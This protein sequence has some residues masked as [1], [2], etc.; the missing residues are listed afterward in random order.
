MQFVSKGTGGFVFTVPA[1]PV[2][3]RLKS[4]P[5]LAIRCSKSINKRLKIQRHA[6]FY[7]T[8]PKFIFF[9]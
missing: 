7:Y 2:L 5:T 4:E 6:H 1:L 8:K 3:P 9:S